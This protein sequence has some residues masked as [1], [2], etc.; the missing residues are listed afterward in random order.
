MI[1]FD[2]YYVRRVIMFDI[3]KH[4]KEVGIISFLL[5]F[6]VII[7]NLIYAQ[8][9]IFDLCTT[10]LCLVSLG[11]GL[12]YI[13][14]GYKKDAAKYYKS[15]MISFAIY[16]VVNCALDFINTLNGDGV[17]VSTIFGV[18]TAIIALM[19]SFKKDLFKA[20]SYTL[21]IA[22]FALGLINLVRALIVSNNHAFIVNVLNLFAMTCFASLFVIAKYA[23]KESRG[24]K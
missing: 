17:F 15:F 23:D 6:V 10:F 24:A 16:A 18:L 20:N 4:L 19:L 13:V 3:K 2:S 22:M 12:F 21:A 1:Y 14:G 11:F 7:V 9:D 5:L 8:R